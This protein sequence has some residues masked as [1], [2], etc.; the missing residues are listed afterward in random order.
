[1]AYVVK[2]FERSFPEAKMEVLQ[3]TKDEQHEPG[4]I[5][6]LDFDTMHSYTAEEVIALGQWLIDKAKYVKA[7]YNS[8]GRKIKPKKDEQ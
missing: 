3:K 8:K 5:I 7:N 4:A 6:D 2:E 1:M